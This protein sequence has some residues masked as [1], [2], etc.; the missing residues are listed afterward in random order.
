MAE[1]LLF[2]V[3]N[4]VEIVVVSIFTG[5][6]M[7]T[8]LTWCFDSDFLVVF[9]EIK[10]ASEHLHDF[11]VAFADHIDPPLT[12]QEQGKVWTFGETV[13]PPLIAKKRGCP[14]CRCTTF[15]EGPS[16]GSST[17]VEC[18]DCYLRWSLVVGS[19]DAIMSYIGHGT[20]YNLVRVAAKFARRRAGI[21][22]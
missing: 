21:A 3:R 18:T 11:A 13:T 16:G 17:N 7:T 14:N 2:G 12:P 15:R 4:L 1:V 8:L 20:E 19:H 5:M 6:L 22:A 10:A 9:R